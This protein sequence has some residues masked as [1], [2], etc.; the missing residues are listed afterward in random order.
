MAKGKPYVISDETRK[1]C[2]IIPISGSIASRFTPVSLELFTYLFQVKHIDFSLY[3]RVGSE[4]IEY[5]KPREFSHELVQKMLMA[6]QKQFD[7]LDICIEKQNYPRFE[8][9]IASTRS[10]KMTQLVQNDSTLDS[11]TLELFGDLSNASQ[12]IVKGGINGH[13]AKKAQKA[14][15]T[16]VN[17]LKSSEV[18]VGTLSRMVLADPTLYDHSAAVSMIAGVICQ[19]M[20]KGDNEKAEKVALGGLYHD[21]GK[22]CV[23]N[24]IL[25]KPGK[26]T[27]EEFEVMKSHTTLGY[28]ELMKAI[29]GGAPIDEEIAIVALEHHE[30]FCG[31]GYPSGKCGRLEEKA[32]GIHYLARIVSIADVYSA[33]LMKRVYKEAFDQKTA[34]DIMKDCAESDYDP[35]I[36]EPFVENIEKSIKYYEQKEA[37]KNKG[38][39]IFV[40]KDKYSA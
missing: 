39:I 13:V 16:L 31:G 8:A 38:K 11:Q 40:G 33:L 24:H 32:D 26:L 34:L 14:A 17:N 37:E 18:A 4:L 28:E 5:I 7:Q 9:I 6:R 20:F 21:V 22:T 30:K 25:N 10:K 2:R 15:H 23:P 29:E 35:V 1:R 3:F 12:M 27:A 36:F 19:Q